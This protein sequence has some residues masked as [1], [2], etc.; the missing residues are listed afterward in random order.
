MKIILL[1]Y[2]SH[3]YHATGF[4]WALQKSFKRIILCQTETKFQQDNSSKNFKKGTWMMEKKPKSN[5]IPK[6]GKKLRKVFI[7]VW[8][9]VVF[10]E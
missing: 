8:I 5:V 1:S 3:I 10:G 4:H 9:S 7:I 6:P 2:K